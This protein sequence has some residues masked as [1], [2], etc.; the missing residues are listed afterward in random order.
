MYIDGM[1][2]YSEGEN[3]FAVEGTVEE[4]MKYIKNILEVKGLDIKIR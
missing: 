1:K 4:R 2:I 3:V